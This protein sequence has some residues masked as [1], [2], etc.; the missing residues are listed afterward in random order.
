MTRALVA[1]LLSFAVL[2]LGIATLAL[3]SRN[4]ARGV[5][6]DRLQ[7][8]CEHLEIYNSQAEAAVV[9]HRTDRDPTEL[10]SPAFDARRV[11]R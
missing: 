2:V 9:E 7:R 10:E 6:L 8:E 4:R 1:V 3:C 11:E 5:A